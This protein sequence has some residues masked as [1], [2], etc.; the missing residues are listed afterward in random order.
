MFKNSSKSGQILVI[1][2]L[3]IIFLIGAIL[4][5]INIAFMCQNRINLQTA[6]DTAARNGAM[7]MAASYKAIQASNTVLAA[8]F[9]IMASP[10]CEP[11]GKACVPMQLC[12]CSK[13]AARSK[14]PTCCG[15][16]RGAHATAKGLTEAQD[17]LLKGLPKL[18]GLA[19]ALS[20]DPTHKI[21]CLPF[22]IK[23][24]N[25]KRAFAVPPSGDRKKQ[26]KCSKCYD[27]DK[28]CG[29]TLRTS[30]GNKQ[31]CRIEEKVDVKAVKL[32]G[33]AYGRP[34]LGQLST[35]PMLACSS[36]KTYYAKK[37]VNPRSDYLEGKNAH[38]CMFS[39]HWDAK[40]VKTD[41]L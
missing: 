27:L 22:R 30:D 39:G 25:F 13:S 23:N 6:A 19:V 12:A 33:D 8:M 5:H 36:A 21:G 15:I 11:K 18:V 41:W 4:M 29:F 20:S 10:C 37:G 24:P 17:L 14:F 2:P 40:T 31:A 35:L 1:V 16:W 38:F 26:P 7:I 34:I 9:S 28:P 3:V 32:G